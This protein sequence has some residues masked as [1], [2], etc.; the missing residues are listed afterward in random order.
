MKNQN[1]GLDY[2]PLN[3]A[4]TKLYIMIDASFAN[5]KDLSF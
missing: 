1:R 5:N 4:A 3:M 2:I